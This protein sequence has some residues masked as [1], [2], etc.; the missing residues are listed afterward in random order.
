MYYEKIVSLDKNRTKKGRLEYSKWLAH[1]RYLKE[2]GRFE[3]KDLP[4]IILWDRYFVTAVILGCADQVLEKMKISVV[5]YEAM[6][7]LQLMLHQYL[8]Y[9]NIKQLEHTFDSIINKAKS[10]STIG[11][12]SSSSSSYSSGGGYGGGSSSG[13]SGGGGGGWSR[14]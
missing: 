8:L 5:D 14:F 6:E 11:K 7:E 2:F 10:N 12:N 9:R 13:S 1:K 3:A 4:E